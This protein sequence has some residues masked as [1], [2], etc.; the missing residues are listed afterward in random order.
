MEK[1]VCIGTG[2]ARLTT[3]I[4]GSWIEESDD[5]TGGGTFRLLA[6]NINP[7]STISLEHL[8]SSS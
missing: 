5:L 3:R 4:L 1:Q 7:A 8:E 6:C 2:M